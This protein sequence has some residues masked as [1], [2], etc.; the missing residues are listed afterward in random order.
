MD[1]SSSDYLYIPIRLKIWAELESLKERMCSDG[2]AP[3]MRNELERIALT[4][5]YAIF[6][7]SEY[8]FLHYLVLILTVE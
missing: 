4:V 1:G 6:N 5:A 2:G 3:S 7:P 8:P